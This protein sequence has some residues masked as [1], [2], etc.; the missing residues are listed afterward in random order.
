M[1]WMVDQALT[2]V[3]VRNLTAPRH[4]QIELWDTRVRGFGVRVSHG[5]AKAFVLVYR[6]NGRPRRITL[7]RY[8]T[9]GLA[10]ARELAN[11][12][13]RAV[14]LGKDPG[15]EKTRARRVP[16]IEHFDAFVDHFIETYSRPKNRT[17]DET[18]RLLKREFVRVWKRR[19]IKEIGK[20]DVTAV[21]DDIMRSGKH[22]T[23]NWSLAAIRKLFNWAVERGLLDQSPCANIRTPAKS[24]KRDRVLSDDELKSIWR[25]VST[26][27]YPYEPIVKILILTAQRREEVAGTSWQELNWTDSIWSMAGARTKSDRPHVVPLSGLAKSILASL[28]RLHEQFVFPSRGNNGTVSGFSKWKSELDDISAVEDWRLHDLRRTTATGMAKLGVPPHVVERILNHASGTFGGVAGIYN[29]FGY[30]PEMREALDRWS[31]FVASLA[32]GQSPVNSNP[33]P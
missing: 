4:G 29:R 12:A 1:A 31:H 20:H 28:P 6:F 23:A 19:P 25:A 8:P 14:D 5:G 16:D 21:L 13:L 26:M 30:L 7:G 10:Q 24:V 33:S 9:L 27:G 22:T 2:D 18:S 11:Q 15:A 3:A 32:E 17:A